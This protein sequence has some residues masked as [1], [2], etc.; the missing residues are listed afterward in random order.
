L[1]TDK[2]RNLRPLRAGG[3]YVDTDTILKSA[4]E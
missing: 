3:T 2:S 1:F 4:K